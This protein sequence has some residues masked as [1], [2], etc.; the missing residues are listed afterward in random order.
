MPKA[1]APLER[2]P[3]KLKKPDQTTAIRRRQRVCVDDGRDRVGGVVEAIDEL[4]AERDEQS[5][6]QQQIGS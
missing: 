2:T 6:D 5:D 4:E 3:R 1:T